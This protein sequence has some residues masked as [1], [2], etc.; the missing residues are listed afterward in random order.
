MSRLVSPVS[1]ARS[2][3]PSTGQADEH[4]EARRLPLALLDCFKP[5]GGASYQAGDYRAAPSGALS[6]DLDT[7][8]DRFIG[9]SATWTTSFAELRKAPGPSTGGV[10]S[11]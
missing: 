9:H 5:F 10:S 3:T 6:D 1:S 7:L 2:R 4:V 8:A 11:A